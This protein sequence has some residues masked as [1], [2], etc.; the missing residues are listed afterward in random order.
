MCTTSN[1]SSRERKRPIQ[2]TNPISVRV[3]NVSFKV[4]LLL[5]FHYVVTERMAI[6]Y[7]FFLGHVWYMGMGNEYGY[8][9]FAFLLK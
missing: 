6:Q 9:V 2:P 8:F 7:K 5:L 4:Y 3:F 1:P